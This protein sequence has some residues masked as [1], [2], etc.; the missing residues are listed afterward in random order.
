METGT[1]LVFNGESLP[2][3]CDPVSEVHTNSP[4]PFS[5]DPFSPFQRGV[6]SNGATTTPTSPPNIG[7][8]MGSSHRWQ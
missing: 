4:D 2:T 6:E 7:Q 8:I 5:P 1:K 3:S